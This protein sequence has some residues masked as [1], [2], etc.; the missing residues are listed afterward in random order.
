MK[1]FWEKHSLGR[2]LTIVLIVSL[3][4]TWIVPI[5]SF[6]GTEFVKGE[7]VRLGLADLGNMLYYVI[8]IAID[9]L[10]FLLVLGIFYAILTK[11]P[12]YKKLVIKI[13][14]KMKGKEVLFA[15]IVSFALALF[16]AFSTNVYAV[17]VFVPFVINILSAMKLD[18]VTVTAVGFG[19]VLVGALGCIFGTEGL[20]TL[21]QYFSSGTLTNFIKEGWIT[22]MIVFI[23]TFGLFTFFNILHMK[24]ALKDKKAESMEDPF[25]I[26]ETKD[27]VAVWPLVIVLS[28]V[29]LITIIGFINWYEYF[30]IE[31][32]NNF[33]T[34]LTEL[35]IKDHA[36]ISYIL[37][38]SSAA[39]GSTGFSLFVLISVLIVFAVILL[40]MSG[41]KFDDMVSSITEGSKKMGK[42]ILPLIAVYVVFAIF[43]LSPMMNTFASGLMKVDGHPDVNIDY[44]GSGIA[45]FNIDTDNDG[46]ADAN[47]VST[48]KDC[49]LNCDT[50]KDGYPDKNMDFDGNGKIDDNDKVAAATY[51]GESVLN[52]DVNGDGNPDVNVD[53]SLSVPGTILTGFIS[54]VF[55]PDFSYTAYT[56]YSYFLSGFAA[57]LS[58]IFIIMITMFGFSAIFVPTSALLV[59][60]LSYTNL[61][62]SKWL[63]YIWR[64]LACT[65]AFL[66]ILYIVLLV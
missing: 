31:V 47:L 43:Y 20:Y 28:L 27:K 16:A 61:E 64:F 21:N 44:K 19:S 33:H 8:A 38:Q 51:D 6:N 45:Y 18:K 39:L 23:A 52:L 9:K 7:V 48:A 59:V 55:H 10:L 25:V 53:T 5:G 12:A 57:N 11:V 63:K 65:F 34:W 37:G 3:F 14:K 60:G 58:I 56:L 13:A 26:E 62:Y 46:K 30:G 35:T 42:V 50:N 2:I 66:I 17:L 4:L 36:V 54:S 41:A 22:R 32:F 40:I 24:A 1:K 29:A 49:K 15:S